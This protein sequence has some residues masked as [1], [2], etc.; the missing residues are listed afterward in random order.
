MHFVSKLAPEE[1]GSKITTYKVRKQ[2]NQE[3]EEITGL[4]KGWKSDLKRKR[5]KKGIQREI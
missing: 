4:R 5:R 1:N 2:I 3:K